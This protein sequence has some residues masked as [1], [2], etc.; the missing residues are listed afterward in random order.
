MPW[1][2]RKAGWRPCA[3]SEL[4]FGE[5]ARLTAEQARAGQG[6]PADADRARSETLLVHRQEQALEEEV[7]V[8]SA[9][10]AQLLNLDPST[11]LQSKPGPGQVL[12]LA[13]PHPP[14]ETLLQTALDNRPEMKAQA[15]AIAAAEARYRQECFR[16]F[17][18]TL[19][20]GYSYG[21]FGGGS[22]LVS[23]SFGN[24]NNRTDVDAVAYWTLEGAGLGNLAPAKARRAEVNEAQ[25]ELSITVNQIRDE[26]AEASA[27][28]AA[29]EQA[30]AVARRQLVRA[31]DGMRRDYLRVRGLEG[32]PIEVINSARLLAAARRNSWPLSPST[33]RPSCSSL[34]TW[35]SRR[36]WRRPR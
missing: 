26:V 11:R 16:P 34:C 28:A 35:D 4:E 21:N 1:S 13:D 6:I 18:P 25:A 7:A 17:L 22:N 12:V 36:P 9:R 23:T 2:E 3:E 24:F 32:R 20:V 33:T 29:R 30:L 31:R 14:L 8:A 10:L 5:I 15:A 27:N 19:F